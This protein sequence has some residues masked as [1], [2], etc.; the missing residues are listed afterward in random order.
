MGRSQKQAVR[1]VIAMLK[2]VELEHALLKVSNVLSHGMY[3]RLALAQTFLGNPQVIILD[4]PTSGLDWNSAQQIRKYIKK[5]KAESTIMISS[6][7]LAEMKELCDYVAILNKGQLLAVGPVEQ[8]TGNSLAAVCLCCSPLP[9]N[10]RLN[11]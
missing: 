10:S 7:N 2:I 1:E 5:L 8:V 4:E 11:K 3:K 9:A 6:H